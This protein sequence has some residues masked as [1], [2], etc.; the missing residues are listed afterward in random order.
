MKED[1]LELFK[2]YIRGVL[3]TGE[4][5]VGVHVHRP[6]SERLSTGLLYISVVP[7]SNLL[8]MRLKTSHLSRREWEGGG[9]DVSSDVVRMTRLF[10]EGLGSCRP[11]PDLRLYERFVRNLLD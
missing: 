6:S 2:V 5:D 11:E 1:G 8:S 4:G 10:V 7:L 9:G 3:T